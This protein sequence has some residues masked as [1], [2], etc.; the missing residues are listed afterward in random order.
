MFKNFFGL[1]KDPFSVSPDTHFLFSTAEIDKTYASLLY[2]IRSRNG[3]ILL[4][5]EVGTGKTLLL[6]K[7]IEEI[8]NETTATAFILSPRMKAAEF[9]D[10]VLSD[11]GIEQNPKDPLLAFKTL[12]EWLFERYQLGQTSLLIVDEA[13]DLSM[14]VFEVV[15]ALTNIETPTEKLLQI[16]LSGQPEITEILRQPGMRTISQRIALRLRTCPLSQAETLQYIAHRLRVAGG[17]VETVFTLGAIK[18][19]STISAGIPRLINLICEHALIAGYADQRRPVGVKTVLEIAREFSLG[20]GTLVEEAFREEAWGPLDI[21]LLKQGTGGPATLAA[22]PA[23][24]APER[25]SAGR[26]ATP[27][28]TGAGTRA[29]TSTEVGSTLQEGARVKSVAPLAPPPTR[30]PPRVPEVAPPPKKEPVSKREAV[31]PF[32]VGEAAE[33]TKSGGP[34]IPGATQGS[35]ATQKANVATPGASK[36]SGDFTARQPTGGPRP[37]E[38]PAGPP[39]IA[40]KST[41]GAQKAGEGAVGA[42]RKTLQPL[43]PKKI[44][45]DRGVTQIENV[46]PQPVGKWPGPPRWA[47]LA[48]VSTIG[49]AVVGCFVIGTWW[50][51]KTRRAM[52]PQSTSH[53]L[54]SGKS[55]ADNRAGLH[56]PPPADRTGVTGQ[57]NAPAQPAT[58]VPPSKPGEVP[59][60]PVPSAKEELPSRPPKPVPAFKSGSS[61]MQGPRERSTRRAVASP[62]P[63]TPGQLTVASN[64]PGATLTL[65]GRSDPSWTTPYTFTDLSPG[66]HTITVS[67]AGY[68]AAHQ[69]VTVEAGAGTSINATLTPPHGEI[70][71]STNPPGAEVLI[72]GKSYGPAPVR[73]EANAGQHTFL[74]RQTGRQPVEG[75]LVVQDQAVVQRTIDLPPTPS[76]SS[77]ANVTVTTQPPSAK[78]YVDGAPMSGKTP[79]SFHLSPGHHTLI[80][81]ADGYRPV[82]REI[83]VVADAALTVNVTLSGQ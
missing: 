49:L 62:L 67:K 41:A 21:G 63:S 81:S 34:P 82:R 37:M 4:V 13:Q 43:L 25:I 39:L 1:A 14:E 55:P 57:E 64:V 31:Q 45:A 35:T 11:F 69:A 30:P 8:Q 61:E 26:P 70:D 2:G 28:P 18:A 65:D 42:P 72:D 51:M 23:Q 16:I 24:P 54:A 7:L 71:I 3:L 73:M 19:V 12:Q 78:L 74:V 66:V 22:A 15:H 53:A 50:L 44:T 79:I 48:I 27:L 58:S 46:S 32:R 80:I 29:G 56:T 33:V 38:S 83:D 75:N 76:A 10:Y 47:S 40:A 9:L 6:R 36:P 17:A 59:G 5:G 68:N 20:G 52:P 77:A 60:I